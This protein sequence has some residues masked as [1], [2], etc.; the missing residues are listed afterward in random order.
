MLQIMFEKSNAYCFSACI[1][2]LS[3]KHPIIKL[4]KHICYIHSIFVKMIT[5]TFN[6]FFSLRLL[7]PY[8]KQLMKMKGDK[9]KKKHKHKHKHKGKQ[10]AGISVLKGFKDNKDISDSSS[11]K[12]V[13]LIQYDFIDFNYVMPINNFYICDIIFSYFDIKLGSYDFFL[14]NFDILVRLCWHLFTLNLM[15]SFYEVLSEHLLLLDIINN[16]LF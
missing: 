16:T 1:T 7:L 8:E 2:D 4:I 12:E 10:T 13:G 9:P 3:W 5:I 15:I 6:F 11:H 14:S